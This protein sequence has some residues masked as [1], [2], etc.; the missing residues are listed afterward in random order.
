MS[1]FFALF[2]ERK[3]A[4]VATNREFVGKDWLGYLLQRPKTPIRARIRESEQLS[5]GSQS[6]SASVVF[7]DL[8]LGETK[9]LPKRRRLWGA[10]AS[11]AGGVGMVD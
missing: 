11:S 7:A 1:E 2:G 4:F 9:V 5:D 8:R 10:I 6:L 3:L